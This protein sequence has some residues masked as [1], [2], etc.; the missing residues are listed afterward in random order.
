MSKEVDSPLMNFMAIF[1]DSLNESSSSLP[2]LSP[3]Q[4]L[5]TYPSTSEGLSSD[6]MC[7][8]VPPPTR[9][10]MR[11]M[12]QN[13]HKLE[14]QLQDATIEKIKFQSECK[15][16]KEE[17][18][19]LLLRGTCSSLSIGV[20]HPSTSFFDSIGVVEIINSACSAIVGVSS[21]TCY[22]KINIPSITITQILV[23]FRAVV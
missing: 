18:K 7:S 19:I 23:P 5:S 13:V 3:P 9:R 16:L 11:H 8:L 21:T 15:Q 20:P 22:V 2:S 4:P 1:S 6:D 12:T 14:E 10:V 17:K